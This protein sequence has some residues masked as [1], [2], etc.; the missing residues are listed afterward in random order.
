MLLQRLVSLAERTT[1]GAPPFFKDRPVRWQLMLNADGTLANTHL[2]DLADPSD[3]ARKNGIARSVPYLTRTVGVAPCLGADDL[4]YVL[5]WCDGKTA[6]EGK[7]DRVEQCHAAFLALTHAWAADAADD[8]VAVA[9]ARFFTSGA[10]AALV[11]PAE[12]SSSQVV[13]IA[14]EGRPVTELPSLQ[15]FWSAEARRRK[16][17]TETGGTDGVCLVCGIP[18]AL[19][20]TLPQQVSSRLIPLATQNS[21]LVSA[22]KPI[23]GYDFSTGL[24]STIPICVDCGRLA[25][26]A[27]TQ[28]IAD[29]KSTLYYGDSRLVWWTVEADPIDL[30]ETLAVDDPESVQSLIDR[31]RS[32][33]MKPPPTGLEAKRFCALTLAGNVSRIM[34]RSWIDLPL[35]ELEANIAAWFT[36]HETTGTWTDRGYYPL[37]QLILASGRWDPKLNQYAN[38]GAGNAARPPD[39]G[40]AL[41]GA[42]LLRKPLPSS[43]LAHLVTRIRDDQCVDDLRAA[44]LRLTLVRSPH[45]SQEDPMPALDPDNRHPAYLA[46]R[47]F[48]A[49]EAIQRATSDGGTINVTFTDR[50][51]AGAVA[52][53]RVALIQGRQLA[54]AWLKKLRRAKPGLAAI[55]D[56][57]L[58]ELFDLID[59]T[60]GLPGRIGVPDQ[61]AF[62]LGYHHQRAAR[63][64][65]ATARANPNDPSANEV[66]D[67]SEA[68]SDTPKNLAITTA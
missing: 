3:R 39:A 57:D 47:I 36:D 46:G 35:A 67:T 6:A 7:S 10:H 1:G 24:N 62:I 58:D 9:V 31:V 23:H 14:V 25:V 12:W 20:N 51:F 16:G 43:L 18:G 34:I 15:R 48:A 49:L 55:L 63:I 37:W 50:Y 17:G 68:H 30:A 29:R 19:C 21:A 44:L 38:L 60:D 61:A 2:V 13:Q 40:R 66:D 45:Q 32:S 5:G 54:A 4:K 27:L 64:R 8:A 52:N 22:N 41:L 33:A 65:A 53:P 56:R 26:E 11:P 28:V 42:A 59:A